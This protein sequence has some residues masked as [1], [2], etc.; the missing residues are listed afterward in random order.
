MPY[1]QELIHKLEVGSW[2]RYLRFSVPCLALVML[3][4][5]YN[6]RSFRNMGT[7]EAMDAAQVARNVSEGKGHTTLFVRPL[8]VHLVKKRNEAKSGLTSSGQQ[9]DHAQ[10]KSMH[11][12]LANPPV[13]P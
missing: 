2:F 5:G 10:L 9:A 12:D 8:S 1:L 3:V 13:Y 11:P 6:W 4:V 7:Q